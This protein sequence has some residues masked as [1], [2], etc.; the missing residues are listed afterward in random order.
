MKNENTPNLSNLLVVN[1]LFLAFAYAGLSTWNIAIPA[2]KETFKLSDTMVMLGGSMLMLGYGVGSLV[3]S[4]LAARIGLKN[5]G[6]IAAIMLLLPQ[7]L[8]PYI[9]S[10]GFILFLRFVQGWGIVWFITVAMVTGWFPLKTRGIASGVVGGSIPVGVGMGGIIAGWLIT[11]AGSWQSTFLIFGAIVLV[12]FIIWFAYVQNPPATQEGST[13]QVADSPTVSPYKYAAGWLVAFALFFN[14]I[15]LIGLYSVLGPYLYSLGYK[16]TQVGTGLLVCGLIG[17]ITTPL[18]GIIGDNIVKKGASPVKARAYIMGFAFL[19]AAV[20]A[21][22]VPVIAP[23]GYA[24]ML[25][26][27]I[28]AGAGV[29]MTN[30]SIGALPTDMLKNPALAGKLFG[31]TI[32]IGAALGGTAAPVL[33]I[34]I[35]SSMGWQAG[36][37]ALGIG[38]ILGCILSF[39][40]PKFELKN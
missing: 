28:L 32:L 39:I 3:E 5:T 13:A 20:T 17:G 34:A 31:M 23:K 15:A 14:F 10:Y 25:F 35:A 6:L 37:I 30:A 26:V 7:F 22:L 36:F 2:L 38:A 11:M 1:F 19:L 29:P 9:P 21:L 16:S 33:G 18:A 27:V 24:A 4:I 8:I 12:V 40:I